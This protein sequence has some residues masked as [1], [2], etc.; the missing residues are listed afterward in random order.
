[1]GRIKEDKK[2][3]I[4][5]YSDAGKQVAK[6]VAKYF[7]AEIIFSP[8][9]QRLQATFKQGTPIIGICASA[10]LIRL[11][12]PL[13]NDK[14]IEPPVIAISNDGK[15]IV[16]L[17]GGHNRANIL[18]ANEMA[19]QIAK[20]I[21]GNAVIT[22]AS[23]SLFSIALDEPPRGYVLADKSL[24]KKAMVDV[25]N[26]AE[27]ALDGKADWLIEAGYD[28][29]TPTPA[30]P[31]RGRGQAGKFP[32]RGREQMG[33]SSIR[34]RGQIEG[35]LTRGRG[36]EYLSE[37]GS[38]ASLSP[39]PL[40]GG[41]RGGGKKQGG[42]GKKQGGGGSNQRKII[43]INISENITKDNILTYHP[44]TLI[45]G[46]GCERYIPSDELIDLVT[47]SLKENNLSPFSIAAITSID[48]K[49]DEKAVN[50]LAEHFDVPLR[51]FSA[52][53]L[54]KEN[55]PNPSKIVKA[56]I[57]TSSVAEACAIK[58]GSLIVEKRKSKRATCAIGKA[59]API[60]IENFGRANGVLHIVGIGPGEALQ[61]TASSVAALKHVSDWVGYGLYLDLVAD[62]NFGQIEHRFGLGDEEKR[63]RHALELAAK[64]KEVA[65]ICSGDGQIYAMASLVFELLE[66]KNERAISDSAKRVE[67][68]SHA[69]ISALQMASNRVGALLGH[70]F[71][72]ISLSDLLTPREAIILRLEAAANAD[73]VS[74]FYNPRSKSRTDLLEKAKDI[75]L[76]YRPKDTP[77]IIARS[78]GR[79]DEQ[80]KIVELANFKTEEVDM[81]SIVLFGSSNSKSFLRGD[82]KRVAFTPRGYDRK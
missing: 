58:A 54:A 75:F 77:V 73:F 5:Y 78:L 2:P 56:E 57:G 27:I 82:G 44:K 41:V 72:A 47:N 14:Q 22:T 37:R 11:L 7:D 31:T 81:M 66:A 26:G 9:K 62:L 24:A 38:K 16:P 17:L 51:L 61:R 32:T 10:I 1:M 43:K 25:L 42:G 3:V 52:Q 8:S 23:N 39:S 80:V 29:A 70:D 71:C 35:L 40:W 6:H 28:V 36:Q 59:K 55:V 63:V 34:G 45:I 64:G 60:D 79:K 48:L 74:A 67:I 19:L 53:E 18:G 49:A 12:A 33:S 76:R 13:L 21:N 65:L 68:I 46:V 20:E 15:H 30:L 4:F 69:G 50:D